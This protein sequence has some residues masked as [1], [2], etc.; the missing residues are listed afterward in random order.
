MGNS[1]YQG[2][3]WTSAF[4]QFASLDRRIE[5]ILD[6]GP[7]QG[8]Y[9]HLLK[10]NLQ[11]CSWDGVEVFKP[12]IDNFNL[13]NFYNNIYNVDVREF[14]P[15]ENYDLI[16]A[17]DVLEHMEKEEAQS[18]VTR[19]LDH[20]RWFLIS[21]PIVK[22]EQDEINGNVHEIHIK[23]DWSHDEVME[24]FDN[25]TYAFIGSH[26]GVYVLHGNLE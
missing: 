4:V 6:I 2:K 22:W 24:S 17:G 20:C 26:I 13:K 15:E 9:F 19:M 7:G 3:E 25:I 1:S 11:G 23:D 5:R 21:I 8:T 18:L 12:Y 14:Y 10:N 16:I